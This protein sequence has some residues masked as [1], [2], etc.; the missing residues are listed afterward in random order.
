MN[1]IAVIVLADS[2]SHADVGRMANAIEIIAE[3]SQAGE[4]AILIFD[5]AGVTWPGKL[6]DQKHPL[7]KKFKDVKSNTLGACAYCSKAFNSENGVKKAGIRLLD[8]FEGHPSIYNLVKEGY[9]II[10]I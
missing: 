4:K 10:T 5:G 2:E 9:Q 6:A 7:F 3:F 8:D 1:R